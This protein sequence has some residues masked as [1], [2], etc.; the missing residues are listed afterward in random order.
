MVQFV[1]GANW[2]MKKGIK[3][4]IE[5]AKNMVEALKGI[6]NVGIVIAPSYTSLKDLGEIFKGTNIKLAAQNMNEN[7]SGAYTG[8]IASDWLLELGC[9]YVILGHSERRRV[10]NESSELIN[11]KVL[12]ALEKGL[13]P[14]LCIGETANERSEGKT[15]QIN[16]QQLEISLK[17]VTAEQMKNFVIAY[18]PVWAINSR[19]LNPTGDIR[20]ATPQEA[21]NV[22][23]FIRKWLVDKFG[24]EIGN[25]IPLQYGGSVKAANCEELFKI[26]DINGG[27]VGSASLTVDAFAP[28]IKMASQLDS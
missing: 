19:A 11:K 8:E 4:S 20:S 10:Y 14:I 7:D 2:K 16:S 25:S 28:I 26:K 18:E 24:L 17:G 27:L 12:K 22:H 6:D 9:E 15:E 21:E 1:I 13:K 23:L 5:T 3:D